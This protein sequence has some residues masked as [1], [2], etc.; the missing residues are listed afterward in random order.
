VG[1]CGCRDRFLG[2]GKNRKPAIS[3]Q[4]LKNKKPRLKRMVSLG[5]DHDRDPGS[6]EMDVSEAVVIFF[7]AHETSFPSWLYVLGHGM[8]MNASEPGWRLSP[9]R[10]EKSRKLQRPRRSLHI[11]PSIPSFTEPFFP[12]I[13][14][15]ENSN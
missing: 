11:Q 1:G 6:K 9:L 2:K 5:E 14:K 12:L 3:W 15:L 8:A 7:R 13:S 10:S 4:A